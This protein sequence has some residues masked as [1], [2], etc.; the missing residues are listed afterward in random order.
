MFAIIIYVFYNTINFNSNQILC[1]VHESNN[2]TTKLCV[3][4]S[5]LL[6]GTYYLSSSKDDGQAEGWNDDACR[7][8]DGQLFASIT[9]W[10]CVINHPPWDAVRDGREDVEEKK[11]QWPVFAAEKDTFKMSKKQKL[12]HAVII[13]MQSSTG[14]ALST[15]SN[16]TG[17]C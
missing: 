2:I 3:L 6:Y 17:V 9:G 10:V 15:L 12:L 7:E 14:T 11:E 16:L 4:L 5:I 8:E 1:N 13:R